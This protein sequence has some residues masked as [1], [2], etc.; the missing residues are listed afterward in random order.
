[1]ELNQKMPSD[2]SSVQPETVNTPQSPNGPKLKIISILLLLLIIVTGTVVITLNSKLKTQTKSSN[3][4][5]KLTQTPTNTPLSGISIKS[6]AQGLIATNKGFT[7]IS[8]EGIPI[9][10]TDGQP[11]FFLPPGMNL[12]YFQKFTDYYSTMV[13]RN[14]IELDNEGKI[15][16][17]GAKEIETASKQNSIYEWVIESIQNPTP[18]FTNPDGKKIVG[19]TLSPDKEAIAIIALTRTEKELYEDPNGKSLSR[20]DYADR[21]KQFEE[22]QKQILIYNRKSGQLLRI[23]KAKE[24]VNSFVWKNNILFVI[25]TSSYRAFDV[26]SDIQLYEA[27]DSGGII[28]SPDGFKYMYVQE[29]VVRNIYTGNVISKLIIPELVSPSQYKS[30]QDA[31]K[32]FIFIGPA[33]FSNNSKKVVFTAQSVSMK[34]IRFWEQDLETNKTSVLADKEILGSDAQQLNP[35]WRLN[36]TFIT[37]NPSDESII[38]PILID[39]IN[40]D[41][42]KLLGLYTYRKSQLATLKSDP[43]LNIFLPRQLLFMGWYNVK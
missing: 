42:S 10:N 29:L 16:F 6:N 37:Y 18:F 26:N 8:S 14:K 7:I 40:G 19:F 12:D 39:S 43:N 15:F 28:F 2:N 24:R 21:V 30:Y 32:I 33:S 31:D 27:E 1:M 5:Q 23:I 11:K 9:K 17:I 22:E 36:F 25:E 3:K 38:F 13:Y 41:V 4:D 34:N 35:S 20:N